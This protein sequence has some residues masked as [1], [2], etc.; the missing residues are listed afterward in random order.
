MPGAPA[1]PPVPLPRAGAAPGGTAGQEGGREEPGTPCAQPSREALRRSGCDYLLLS[2]CLPSAAPR[3]HSVST[4]RPPSRYNHPE[5]AP[6]FSLLTHTNPLP[7]EV[8]S[9]EG[10]WLASNPPLHT[11]PGS[12][13]PGPVTSP[14]PSPPPHLAGV[15]WGPPTPSP[16][17]PTNLQHGPTRP[18]LRDTWPHPFSAGDP[19][20]S[21]ARTHPQAGIRDVARPP[22][23]PSLSPVVALGQATGN[24]L[25]AKSRPH[26]DS[27]GVGQV[28]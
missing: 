10:A 4:Q 24:D 13:H 20:G 19:G 25:K 17:L 16:T 3:P 1:A 23:S 11:V 21:S 27:A 5:T 15:H 12:A 9:G 2:R 14:T 18:R 7:W 8:T 28:F 26:T 6:C 22:P